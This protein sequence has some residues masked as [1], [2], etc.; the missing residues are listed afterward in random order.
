V[1]RL[2]AA[3]IALATVHLVAPASA[4]DWPSR[5]VRIISTFAA[6]G[7]ADVLARIVAEHMSTAFGQ[8]FFV[9]VRAGAAGAIGVQ[10][11]VNS[12]PDGYNFVITNVSLLAL[13][14]VLN[15]KL[16]YDPLRDL[17]NVGYIAGSPIVLSV[18][19]ASG[20]KTLQDFIARAKQSQKP[21]TYSSSG[22]GSSGQLVVE[23]FGKVANL[24]FEHV[25]YRG[26]SQGLTD[27][28]GGHIVFS[29]QTLSSTAALLRGGAL[30][31]IGITA[32]ERIADFPDIPTFK[33]SGYPE[34]IANIWFAL[35][36]PAGLPADI[37]QKVNTEIIKAVSKPQ[38]QEKLRQDGMVTE[39]LSPE[40]LRKLVETE[41]VR[42]KPI[43][44]GS[45]LLAK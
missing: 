20:I 1:R 23:L 7:T 19:A 26:A 29:S 40:G 8:Q 17:T 15:P 41:T 38:I 18:S 12:P 28:V 16:G 35:S 6:G 25:P 22:L 13:H 44:E 21:L 31:G 9:E 42:W 11:V 5:P 45:G 43:I 3:L 37:V 30:Q 2:C 33:E 14:P 36:G 27:L 24:K 4:Q 32:T 34:V 39:A 10:A